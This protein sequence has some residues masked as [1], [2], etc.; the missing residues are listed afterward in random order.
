MTIYVS[1]KNVYG[2][3]KVYPDC[4]KAKGFAALLNQK[5]FTP[6]NIRQMKALGITFSVNS[7][8]LAVL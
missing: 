4:D 8:A 3:E 2:E 1:I 5:T 6:A 7:H